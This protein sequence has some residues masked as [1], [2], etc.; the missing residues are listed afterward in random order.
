[1]L[2]N[3]IQMQETSQIASYFRQIYFR[4]KNRH[5]IKVIKVSSLYRDFGQTIKHSNANGSEN[6]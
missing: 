5:H 2:V 4:S 3:H 1:M 6:C